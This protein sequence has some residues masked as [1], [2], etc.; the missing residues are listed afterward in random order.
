MPLLTSI[1]KGH[2][3]MPSILI[4]QHQL[5]LW[6]YYFLVLIQSVNKYLMRIMA[7]T[8][9]CQNMLATFKISVFLLF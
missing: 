3:A 5:S 9:S 1:T 7:E 6:L 2:F 8:K 4:V